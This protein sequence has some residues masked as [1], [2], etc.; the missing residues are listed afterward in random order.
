MLYGWLLD[1]N[2]YRYEPL[3]D[4]SYPIVLLKGGESRGD[5][6]I[7]SLGGDLD[8]VL[9]VPNVLYRNCAVSQNHT[10]EHSIFAFCSLLQLAF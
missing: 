1:K 3:A 9:N 5:R 2:R 10:L 7:E 4:L 8:G 6:F